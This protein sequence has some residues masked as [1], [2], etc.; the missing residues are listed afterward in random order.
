MSKNFLKSLF[1]GV[2][3]VSCAAS[4]NAQSASQESLI[5][6]YQAALTQHFLK[7]KNAAIPLL[8]VD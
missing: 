2:V 4:A 6:A 3:W 5:S 8:H 1:A 7:L